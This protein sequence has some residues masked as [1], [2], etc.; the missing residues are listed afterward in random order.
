MKNKIFSIFLLCYTLSQTAFAEEQLDRIEGKVDTVIK[1]QDQVL[2]IID[3]D[4]LKGKKFGVEIN[5]VRILLVDKKEKSFS[6]TLSFFNIRPNTEI[7][8]PFYFSVTDNSDDGIF[9]YNKFYDSTVDLHYRFF[10]GKSTNGFYMSAISRLAALHGDV[11]DDLVIFDT[12]PVSRSRETTIKL[13]VG[14]GIGYRIFSS[15]GWYWGTSLSAGRYLIGDNDK[16]VSGFLNFDDDSKYIFDF[17][18]LKFGY[19]F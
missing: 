6:G 5:P 19:A 2:E 12:E 10:L 13:G 7:A 3:A 15:S 9:S 14:F 18:L 1:K 11:G 16:H 8:I 4:P 17:E